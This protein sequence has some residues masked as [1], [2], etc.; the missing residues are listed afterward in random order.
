MESISMYAD[1]QLSGNLSSPGT[2]L[3]TNIFN[4]FPGSFDS[5]MQSFDD[6][7]RTV[8]YTDSGFDAPGG[9]PEFRHQSLS[10]YADDLVEWLE[11]NDIRNIVYLAHSVNGM[12]SLLAAAKAPHLFDKIILISTAPCFFPRQNLHLN[13]ETGTEEREAVF[14]QLL[15]R[16]RNTMKGSQIATQLQ[17]VLASTITGMPAEQATILFSLVA[18]TDCRQLLSDVVTPTMILQV[19]N[20][21]FATH[22]AGYFMYRNMPNSQ[23]YKINAKGQ[24]PQVTAPEEIIMAMQFFVGLPV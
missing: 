1:I 3:V 23:L 6:R 18:D 7:Y 19:S 4:L 20:D 21:Q 22:E 5:V 13:R 8:V 11:A 12:L 10:E 9:A 14:Q 2:L 16:S 24:L 15:H 17:D